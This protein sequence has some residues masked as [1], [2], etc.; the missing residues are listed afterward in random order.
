MIGRLGR[1]GMTISTL[2]QNSNN[3]A[4]TNTTQLELGI[5]SFKSKFHIFENCTHGYVSPS[6]KQ[7]RTTYQ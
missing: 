2:P 1:L 5:R 6:R 7:A 4:N 3:V